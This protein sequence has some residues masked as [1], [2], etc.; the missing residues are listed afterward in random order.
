MFVYF[1][2][3]HGYTYLEGKKIYGFLEMMPSTHISY[4]TWRLNKNKTL[5][6]EPFNKDN[7]SR[8]FPGIEFPNVSFTL[9]DIRHLSW[10][11]MCALCKAFGLKTK[12]DNVSRRTALRKF[13]K[14]HC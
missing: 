11:D 7:L 1:R 6:Q 10:D 12:R 3:P 9:N 4:E 8:L 2:Y 13:I 14:E 5:I